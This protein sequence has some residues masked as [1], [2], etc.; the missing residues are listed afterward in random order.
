MF[1][2]RE[3]AREHKEWLVGMK[4]RF[5]KEKQRLKEITIAYRKQGRWVTPEKREPHD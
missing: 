2:S 3:A 5:M 4:S 1:L